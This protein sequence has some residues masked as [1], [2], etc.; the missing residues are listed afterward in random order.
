MPPDGTP[1]RIERTFAAPAAAVFDAWTSASVLRQWWPAGPDWDTTVA[2]VD[3]RV[4][5]GLRLV[6]RSP[7][8][9]EFGGEGRYVEI[10]P[11]TRLVFTWQ[12]D[13]AELGTGA[14]LVEVS[15][16][17]NPD[18]TTTV[19]LINRGLTESEQQSHLEGWQASFDN[20]DRV[21]SGSAGGSAPSSDRTGQP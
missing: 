2:E 19:V 7:D 20:L 5:G 1:L 16:T 6:M 8:G 11:P 9:A 10:T 14:Q 3:V 17:E 13:A 18:S 4:G 15:F 21:F 12:W